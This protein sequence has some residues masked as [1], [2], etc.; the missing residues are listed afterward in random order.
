MAWQ[1]AGVPAP[2]ATI[3][4]QTASLTVAVFDAASASAWVPTKAAET[5]AQFTGHPADIMRGL[6]KGEEVTA[7]DVGASSG[8]AFELEG[9]SGRIELYR[10][11]ATTVA[12]L[13]PPRAWWS[14]RDHAAEVDALFGDA[15][16]VDGADAATELGE[17]DLAS[18]KLAV[19]Y[20]WHKKVAAAR[21]LDVPN[22]GAV[23]FGDGYGEGDGGMVVDL[24]AG[25]HR[26]LKRELEAPWEDGPSLVVMYL[27]RA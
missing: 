3:A 20:M 6:G 13:A 4:S 9:K 8:F 21:D 25:S 24:G 14:E 11:D 22:T 26:L 23:A 5:K 18:G 17:V 12:L 27:R 19:V 7:I 10:I 16:A 1:A 15:L 2:L